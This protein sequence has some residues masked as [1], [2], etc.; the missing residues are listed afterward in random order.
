MRALSIYTVLVALAWNQAT[1][2]ALP[3]PEFPV[4][5]NP[6]S[7]PGHSNVASNQRRGDAVTTYHPVDK[8]TLDIVTS[9]IVSSTSKRSDANTLIETEATTYAEEKHVSY[10]RFQTCKRIR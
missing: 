2:V 1:A 5:Q 4:I 3:E 10:H 6:K 8:S 9:N 7:G